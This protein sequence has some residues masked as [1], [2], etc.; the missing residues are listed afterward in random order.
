MNKAA[1][2]QHK[3]DFAWP[4]F[5]LGHPDYVNELS[6]GLVMQLKARQEEAGVE[7]LGG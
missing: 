2:V 3:E 7:L 4:I 6:R 5:S 1:C